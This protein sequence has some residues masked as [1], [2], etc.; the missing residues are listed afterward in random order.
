MYSTEVEG[1][2]YIPKFF[3]GDG[4]L[5]FYWDS[6][7]NDVRIKIGYAGISTALTEVEVAPQA[8]YEALTGAEALKSFYDPATKTF[9]FNVL[10]ITSD[11]EGN[12]I[13]IVSTL[14]F[15]ITS[16]VK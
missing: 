6:K 11:G 13:K 4:G 8:D 7:T 15:K 12:L 2:Y 9:T 5:E 14:Y 1:E 3:Q 16:E 10:M